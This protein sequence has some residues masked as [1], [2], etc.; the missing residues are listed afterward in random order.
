MLLNRSPPAAS[1]ITAGAARPVVHLD[2]ADERALFSLPRLQSCSVDSRPPAAR[3]RR[4]PDTAVR[5]GLAG[6]ADVLP[7]RDCPGVHIRPGPLILHRS[8]SI[9]RRRRRFA[10]E[11]KEVHVSGESAGK[12]GPRLRAPDS[13]GEAHVER[14]PEHRARAY[15]NRRGAP[16][17]MKRARCLAPIS[18]SGSGPC[19]LSRT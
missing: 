10:P 3:F 8:R 1:A 14:H 5:P 9:Y 18:R 7:Q 4:R 12:P 16:P 6:G 11:G 15:V 2:L 19:C 13:R 17:A